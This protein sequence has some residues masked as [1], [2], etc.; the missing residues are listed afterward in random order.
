[1]KRILIAL[2]LLG[3][4]AVSTSC[5]DLYPRGYGY[6][7]GY[8]QQYRYDSGYWVPAPNYGSLFYGGNQVNACYPPPQRWSNTW[9]GRYY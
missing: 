6:G 4:V 1:M 9:N 5:M 3:I 8:Q 2:L 7:Y